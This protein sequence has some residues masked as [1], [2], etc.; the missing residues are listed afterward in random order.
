MLRLLL[1]PRARLLAVIAAFGLLW[2][3][4]AGADTITFLGDTANSTSNLGNFSAT[5][6]YTASSSTSATLDLTLTNTSPAA[7][8]GFLTAFVLNNPNNSITSVTQG[9]T[10]GANFS[11]LG[12]TNN[13]VK[14]APYGQFDFGASTGGS[15]E[16]G[17]NPSK[18]I[19]VGG[20]E[21]FD[22]ILTGVGLKTLNASSFAN[23]LSVGP[24][25]GMGD[26]FFVARFRGFNNGG[27]DKVPGGSPDGGNT[28]GG[29]T[30]G[31][32]TTGGNNTGGNNT[33]GSSGGTNGPAVVPE[34][35][36]MALWA[37]VGLGLAGYGVLRR[38]R[39]R[40][41]DQGA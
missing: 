36:S 33:G 34:P 38:K 19:G 29:N 32:N 24:G 6:T 28:T 8:G 20:S 26:Q 11:V 10:F 30:T 25:N 15:F 41:A 21:T 18:G 5:L 2:A 39:A 4:P 3:V 16:G 31:G 7:N 37:A 27:S 23:E 22:F 40:H 12:L 17:G 14:G 13:G 9:A 35:A 1:R